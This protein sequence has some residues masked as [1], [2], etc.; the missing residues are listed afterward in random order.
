MCLEY[1]TAKMP[2][3]LRKYVLFYGSMY[4]F[5]FQGILLLLNYLYFSL[6]LMTDARY[7]TPDSNTEQQFSRILLDSWFVSGAYLMPF[8]C[9]SP[10]GSDSGSVASANLNLIDG[11]CADIRSNLL[12]VFFQAV[13][14]QK[15]P[16]LYVGCT[17]ST[18][19]MFV[20]F[21]ALLSLSLIFPRLCR[22]SLCKGRCRS[23]KSKTKEKISESILWYGSLEELR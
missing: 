17:H 14:F 3:T 15:Q 4:S 20:H 19:Y 10:N 6:W 1:Q 2:W 21:T 8:A 12:F 23:G 22:Y 9:N 16:F 7:L 18:L 11:I 13:R 5:S